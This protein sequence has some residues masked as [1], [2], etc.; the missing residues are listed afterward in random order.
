MMVTPISQHSSKVAMQA[1]CEYCMWMSGVTLL[2]EAVK[3]LIAHT[4]KE[5]PEHKDDPMLVA[6]PD[7]WPAEAPSA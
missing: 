2:D 6:R 3:E 4:L 1:Y 5:H 7:L